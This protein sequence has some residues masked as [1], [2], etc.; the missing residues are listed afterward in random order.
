MLNSLPIDELGNWCLKCRQGT[1]A[2]QAK[3][4]RYSWQPRGQEPPLQAAANWHRHTEPDQWKNTHRTPHIYHKVGNIWRRG[5]GGDSSRCTSANWSVKISMNLQRFAKTFNN[6]KWSA[7]I[8][9]DLQQE[10]QLISKGS[11]KPRLLIRN[12]QHN[13]R[14]RKHTS[15]E[16]RQHRGGAKPLRP[17]RIISCAHWLDLNFA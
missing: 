10:Q 2:L 9:K 15:K 3:A 4:G 8:C 16:P 14:I 5:R 6:A 11:Y 1:W 12:D 17:P 7:R 13:Q